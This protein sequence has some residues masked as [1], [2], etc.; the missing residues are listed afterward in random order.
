M[1]GLVAALVGCDSAIE[2]DDTATATPSPVV[3]CVAGGRL[4]TVLFGA[5]T[6]PLDWAAGNLECEGM[7]RPNGQGGR[8]RFAGTAAATERRIAI[9]IG[10][11]ALRRGR[12]GR[13][14]NS[15]VTLLE[16]GSGR[17]FSTASLES[18]WTDV[19]AQYAMQ[20]SA[21]RVVISGAVY[22]VSPL[23]E[24]NGDGSVS[25]PELEFTGL[26]DWSA[27]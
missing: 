26:L 5:L 6:G 24:V 8:L 12:T 10:I 2:S 1:A 15:N 14:L 4:E 11:P 13:E 17:F 7:P 21:D 25:I 9:I 18:C 19:L 27:K 20:G 16:E 23:A 3:S 22:C